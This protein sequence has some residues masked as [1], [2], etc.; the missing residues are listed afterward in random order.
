MTLVNEDSPNI[1]HS[2]D[3]HGPHNTQERLFRNRN[4][5]SDKELQ[6]C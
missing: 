2:G 5:V 1:L 6:L 3:R 4:N